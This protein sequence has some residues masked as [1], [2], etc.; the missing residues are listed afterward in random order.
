MKLKT[1][2]NKE[3][4]LKVLLIEDTGFARGESKGPK[5]RREPSNRNRGRNKG[6]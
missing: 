2:E 6:E 1:K 3:H 4:L 5:K